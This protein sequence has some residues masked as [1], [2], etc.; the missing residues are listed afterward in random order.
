M[1]RTRPI[2]RP[3]PKWRLRSPIS[4]VGLGLFGLLVV[5]ILLLLVSGGDDRATPE[6]FSFEDAAAPAVEHVHGLGINPGDGALYVATH[7]GTF[8]VTGHGEADR[9]GD[10]FQD[11]MGFTVVGADHFF[12]SG[13]PDV[14]A[15]REGAPGLLGLIESTD[16]GGEWR[17]LSLGGEVDFH[18][19]AS[20]H[21]QVYGWDASSG[22]FL[23][24]PD[25]KRWDE[26]ST[27]DLQS[28]AVDPADPEHI[29]A[30]LA[31]GLHDS[32][33]GGRTWELLEGPSPATLSWD[34]SAGLWAAGA[35]GTVHRSE[36]GRAWTAAG[37]LP[38][39]PQAFL[40]GD[41]LY[42]AVEAE[43]VTSIVSSTNGGGTWKV[44]HRDDTGS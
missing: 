29:V 20:A 33:D 24:S 15:L 5:A 22:R 12:G 42:A 41:Q 18:A 19:L 32:I 17:E 37:R 43:G 34:S 11:T 23:V 16:A 3:Q 25:G 7:F 8:R 21:G 14:P 26:R 44:R 1:P 39:N 40:A 31:A 6:G 9:I 28:F 27:V 13:H 10:S 38:G 35:D 4:Y 36:D 2:F 30:S